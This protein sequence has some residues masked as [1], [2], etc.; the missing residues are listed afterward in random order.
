MWCGRCCRSSEWVEG[1]VVGPVCGWREVLS[2]HCVGGGCT[3]CG[4]ERRACSLNNETQVSCQYIL[5]YIIFNSLSRLDHKWH[6]LYFILTSS[7]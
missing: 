7:K 6:D 2:V 3:G 4:Y 1:G 5:I